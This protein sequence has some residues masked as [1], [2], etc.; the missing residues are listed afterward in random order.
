MDFSHR[1]LLY[2]D[3]PAYGLILKLIIV[4]VPVLSLIGSVTLL[5]SGDSSGAMVLLF[6]TFFIVFIFWAVFPRWYQVYEDHLR[7]V[8]GG[9]FSVKIRFDNIKTITVTSGL[10]LTANYVTRFTRNPV[11]IGVKKGLSVAI[12]PQDSDLFIESANSALSRWLE[13]GAVE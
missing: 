3:R 11:V 6:E 12:T 7:I 10:S 2:R 13:A 1:L 5:L 4:V 8:L 9:P